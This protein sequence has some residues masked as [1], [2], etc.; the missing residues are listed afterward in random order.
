MSI[1]E[2]LIKKSYFF[3]KECYTTLKDSGRIKNII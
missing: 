1:F 3:E 2:K